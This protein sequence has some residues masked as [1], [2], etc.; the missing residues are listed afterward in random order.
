M[1]KNDLTWLYGKDKNYKIGFI[2]ALFTAD[3]SV[4]KNNNVE[5]YSINEDALHVISNILREFGMYVNLT[6]HSNPRR[7]MATDGLMRDNKKVYKINISGGQFKRIGFLSKIKNNLLTKQ[8]FKI[9]HRLKTCFDK[10]KVVSIDK[11]WSIEDVYDITVNDESHAFIDTSVITHNCAEIF[12]R[13]C[14]A[15]NLTS[16]ICRK[17]DTQK[18]LLNKVRIATIIGTYQATFTD[19]IYLSKI[20]KDNCDEERLLGVSLNGQIS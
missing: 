4:R 7:Y 15:C 8:I 14:Q 1:N 16:V 9:Q 5:L 17:E 2:K 6:T 12:L 11:E 19:F 13:S 18:S 10:V 3:G 20:W